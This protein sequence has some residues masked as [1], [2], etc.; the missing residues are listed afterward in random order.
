M[1]ARGLA[2]WRG[3][4][5]NTALA[6]ARG[7]RHSPGTRRQLGGLG[8]QEAD[9]VMMSATVVGCK[10]LDRRAAGKRR[11]ERPSF[12]C[13][14][15][16][17]LGTRDRK[18]QRTGARH[19]VAKGRWRGIQARLWRAPGTLGADAALLLVKGGEAN[20]GGP[21]KRSGVRRRR[22]LWSSS[23]SRR[24]LLECRSRRLRSS[25]SERSW[26]RSRSSLSWCPLRESW[27]WLSRRS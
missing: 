27:A 10:T 17:T 21:R 18:V 20:G 13:S 26:P 5:T 6:R 14:L 24:T 22:R 19:T 7:G 2:G 25:Q 16:G 9:S 3:P 12:P 1:V 4:H 23:C 15:A 8:G 11:E